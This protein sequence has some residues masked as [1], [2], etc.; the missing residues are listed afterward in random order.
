MH[1]NRV[2]REDGKTVVDVDR[3]VHAEVEVEAG[4]SLHLR[5]AEVELRA[6]EVLHKAV[7]VVRLGDDGN[8]PLRSP[9]ITRR[10]VS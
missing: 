7:V 9:A 10:A 2:S 4:D 8:T 6:L 3:V 5:I 1:A